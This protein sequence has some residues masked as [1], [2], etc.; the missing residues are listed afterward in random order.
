MSDAQNLNYMDTEQVTFIVDI[1]FQALRNELERHYYSI[2]I[3]YWKN[4]VGSCLRY[5]LI[6]F[7]MLHVIQ[8]SD[9]ELFVM[10]VGAQGIQSRTQG[11]SVQR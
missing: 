10:L 11:D 6:T 1:Y 4:K 9:I 8:F 5:R 7:L 3:K 2:A